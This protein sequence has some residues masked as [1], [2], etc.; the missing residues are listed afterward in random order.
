MICANHARFAQFFRCPVLL[1]YSP[2]DLSTANECAVVLYGQLLHFPF[3]AVLGTPRE[4]SRDGRSTSTLAVL[5]HAQTIGLSGQSLVPA[6]S[7]FNA[8]SQ[9]TAGSIDT[10]KPRG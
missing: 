1:S 8:A 7:A 6:S 2:R 4:S 3:A 9:V 5:V 10:D